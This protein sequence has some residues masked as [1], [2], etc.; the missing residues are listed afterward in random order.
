MLTLYRGA[1]SVTRK[2]PSNHCTTS[3]L[4]C[5]YTAR[6]I[7]R[8]QVVCAKFWPHHSNVAAEI[9]TDQTRQCFSNRFEILCTWP[10]VKC[11]ICFLSLDDGSGTQSG[12]L[13]K[14]QCVL[15]SEMLFCVCWL[16]FLSIQ[17]LCFLHRR[18]HIHKKLH[19]MIKGKV[20]FWDLHLSY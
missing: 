18:S 8:I 2:Y 12:L 9:E 6:R 17:Y 10:H 1:K 20:M 4:N 15:H 13:L 7:S 19:S 3:S 16:W 14:I 11:S 5:G